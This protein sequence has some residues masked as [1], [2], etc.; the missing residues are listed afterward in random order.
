ME[1]NG[2]SATQH[3]GKEQERGGDSELPERPKQVLAPV[4]GTLIISL[5]TLTISLA[6][7]IPTDR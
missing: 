4:D 7:Q 2:E 1:K 6:W 5:A 3:H